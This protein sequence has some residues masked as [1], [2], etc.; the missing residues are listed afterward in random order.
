MH[1]ELRKDYIQEKYVIIAPRRSKRPHQIVRPERVN[2][3]PVKECVFCPE[4]VD[5]VKD[6]LTI[7]PKKK[8]WRVKVIKNIFPAV[9]FDNPKSYG[10]QEVVIETPDH[11]Q[12]LEDLPTKHIAD[13]LK[14]YAQRTKKLS[15]NSKLEYII[16][17]KILDKVKKK[18]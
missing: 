2:K 12:E 10:T 5:K 4:K 9:T 15:Q 18:N 17:F 3:P 8:N 16:I 14:A 13:L 7:G 1:S 6:L 11:T